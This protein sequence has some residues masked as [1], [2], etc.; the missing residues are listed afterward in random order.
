MKWQ[1]FTVV[2]VFIAL[3]TRGGN[4]AVALNRTSMRTVLARAKVTLVSFVRRG[5]LLTRALI[6]LTE[7]PCMQSLG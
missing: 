2:V 1:D 4:C 7:V 6:S 3:V 5:T